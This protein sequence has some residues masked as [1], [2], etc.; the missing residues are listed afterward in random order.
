MFDVQWWQLIW[1][2]CWAENRS[3]WAQAL[4][5]ILNDG[6]ENTLN[7]FHPHLIL[8]DL[9]KS[10]IR[11]IYINGINFRALFNLISKAGEILQTKFY[12]SHQ[13]KVKNEKEWAFTMNA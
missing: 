6:G 9:V 5:Y 4:F 12:V 2:C 13:Y 7:G 11:I 10:E 1:Q 3:T 8:S